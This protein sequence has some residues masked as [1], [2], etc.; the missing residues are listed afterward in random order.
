MPKNT[1]VLKIFSTPVHHQQ[2]PAANDDLTHQLFERHQCEEVLVTAETGRMN[3]D[4]KDHDR[5]HD[6]RVDVDPNRD[7]VG[8][9]RQRQREANLAFD[10]GRE[11]PADSIRLYSI[12]APAHSYLGMTPYRLGAF[13]GAETALLGALERARASGNVRLR[14]MNVHARQGQLESA[15]EQAVALLDESADEPERTALGQSAGLAR[16]VLVSKRHDK[17]DRIRRPG[18]DRDARPSDASGAC[19]PVCNPVS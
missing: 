14:L 17:I 1:A 16:R 18:P 15:L 10:Q 19:S 9:S 5:H 2:I 7:A 11:F 6:N 3:S 4:R 12:P 13:R 8:R